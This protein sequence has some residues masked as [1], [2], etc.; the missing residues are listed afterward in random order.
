MNILIIAKAK[1]MKKTNN[2]LKVLIRWVFNDGNKDK[3]YE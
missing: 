2:Q 3:E 1:I